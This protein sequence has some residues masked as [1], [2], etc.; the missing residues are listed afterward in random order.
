MS[1]GQRAQFTVP[2][3][4]AY[5]AEGLFPVVP[6]NAAIKYEVQLID[7][8]DSNVELTP[9]DKYDREMD[10]TPRTEFDGD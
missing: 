4:L 6:P 7:F 10:G 2:A 8:F 5:G 3:V 9:R 1:R